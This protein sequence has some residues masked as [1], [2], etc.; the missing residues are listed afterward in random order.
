VK[1]TVS[2]I[3]TVGIPSKYGGFE[4]LAEQLSFGIKDEY[5]VIVACSKHH[6]KNDEDL[7]YNGVQRIF[8]PLNP[9]GLSS[10]FYDLISIFKLVSKS[11]YLLILGS[12]SAFAIP[13]IHFFWRKIM[14]I[15]HPDGL[16]W[17]RPKWNRFAKLYLKFSSKIGTKYADKIIIDNTSL[18]SYHKKYIPKIVQISY[19]GNQYTFDKHSNKKNYWLTIA[20]SEP[21][22]NLIEI[23]RFFLENETENWII[24]T[25]ISNSKYGKF[26]EKNLINKN[27]IC[28]IDSIYDNKTISTL[29]N[30]CKGYI[31]GH[32]TGGTNPTLVAA[33]WAKI[34]VVCHDNPFNRS[35]TNNLAAY[36]TDSI[37]LRSIILSKNKIDS[38]NISAMY[39]FAKEE[40]SW[41]KIIFQYRSLFKS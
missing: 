40:Y 26:I 1:K 34:P 36:F 2:I 10:I 22:N 8:I 30:E 12:S 13:F 3:G 9:N 17:E 28:L 39:N 24:V 11:D 29:L 20:R 4:T 38:I 31:H 33:M 25:N 35:T 32:S 7:A 18:L 16:E 37:N 19:G 23:A 21:E 15:F 5:N 6:Y 14:V 27:N 41:E